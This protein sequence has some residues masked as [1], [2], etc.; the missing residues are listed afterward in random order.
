MPTRENR[1]S[2]FE[3]YDLG[4]SRS[5]YTGALPEK[6]SLDSAAFESLWKLHPTEYHTI[7]MMGRLV[8]TPRWQQA[9]GMDYHYTGRTNMARPVTGLLA[10]VLAWAQ[11]R[12]DKRLNG[13]L[14][15]WYDGSLKHYIGKHRD[16]INNLIDDVAI[17]T[18]SFCEERVLRLRPHQGT[19][20]R[21][22]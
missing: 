10:P 14:V 15:N 12:I 11:E 3:C 4:D 16:S 5:F 17:V 21:D 8:K 6:L 7:K 2:D 1:L 18:I 9:Y 13:I 20:Y 22:L 19:G